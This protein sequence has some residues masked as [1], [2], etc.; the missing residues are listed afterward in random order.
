[1][2]DEPSADL[3]VVT[4]QG[5]ADLGPVDC[6]SIGSAGPFVGAWQKS[7]A[8]GG[9]GGTWKTTEFEGGHRVMGVASWVGTI[10]AAQVSDAL[11][12]SLDILPTFASLAGVELPADRVYDGVDIS[13]ILLHGATQAHTTLFHPAGQARDAN[14]P[15]A[16]PAM[17]MGKYKAHFVTKGSKSCRDADGNPRTGS[18]G[19]AIEHDPPLVF[20]L[21]KDPGE[22]TPLDPL[23]IVTQ[24][25]QMKQLYAAFW[26]SVNSTFRSTTNYETDPL[27]KP[28]SNM[29]SK[30]CRFPGQSPGPRLKTDDTGPPNILFILADDLVSRPIFQA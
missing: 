15:H 5:P 26:L 12:S 11:V 21:D 18:G 10:K 7:A 27:Y 8:G 25:A 16:V 2:G 22:S 13:D 4:R 9:G 23:T 30:C 1:M 24:I 14:G 28:C 3:G 29:A 19:Q 6:D 17:R 20:D